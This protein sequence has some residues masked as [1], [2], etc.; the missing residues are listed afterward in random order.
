MV[1]CMMVAEEAL[2]S[3]IPPALPAAVFS[4]TVQAVMA[5]EDSEMQKMPPPSAEPASF[6]V[7]TQLL[8]V[9]EDF[10]LQ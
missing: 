6:P 8:I 9:G 1:Q 10:W 2:E 7:I 5:G 3:P 4:L